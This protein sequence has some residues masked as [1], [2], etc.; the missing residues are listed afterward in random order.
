MFKRDLFDFSEFDIL[1]KNM[2]DQSS[3]FSTI[4]NTDFKTPYPVD[5]SSNCE[6]LKMEVAIV[7]ADEKDIDVSVEDDI[8]NVKY[9]K[10]EISCDEPVKSD[11][12]RVYRIQ[13]K[14][15][16]RRSFD[17]AWR[18]SQKYD[19]KKLNATLDKGLLT[20]II[21]IAENKKAEKI[22]INVKK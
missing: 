13:H 9:T 6:N 16:T 8:L 11:S 2:F 22:Q 14:G 18:I 10:P 7:G 21:P 20:I 19:L 12:L 17:H 1:F 15:I 3:H 5:V 4:V